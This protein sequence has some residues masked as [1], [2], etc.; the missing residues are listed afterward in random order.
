MKSCNRDSTFDTI[1]DC[2]INGPDKR[3]THLTNLVRMFLVHGFVPT[4]VLI[5]T[6]SPLTKDNLGD[7]TA[8]DNYRAIAGGCLLVK[9]IDIVIL[10]TFLL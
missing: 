6:L 1:S 7:M 4:S 8:S 2:F 10:Q 5:C 3:I 9:L